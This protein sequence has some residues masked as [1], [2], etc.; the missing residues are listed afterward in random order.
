[1]SAGVTYTGQ[2][3]LFCQNSTAGEGIAFDF[4]PAAGGITVTTFHAQALVF[5]TALLKSVQ[6]TALA[7]DIT[8]A[9]I[10]GAGIALIDFTVTVNA[11]G[12]FIPRFSEN[13]GHVSGTATI[14]KGSSISV[15]H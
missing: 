14:L 1:M 6:T 10:T 7:T 12:N 2:I 8:V 4:D 5:D 13:S 9:T 3:T 15:N 11:A